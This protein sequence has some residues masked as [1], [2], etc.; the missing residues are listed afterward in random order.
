MRSLS[1]AP[2]DALVLVLGFLCGAGRHALRSTCTAMYALRT[3]SKTRLVVPAGSWKAWDLCQR[4]QQSPT[5]LPFWGCHTDRLVLLVR[6]VR[7]DQGVPEGLLTALRLVLGDRQPALVEVRACGDGEGQQVGKVLR[8]ANR[9]AEKGP[10]PSAEIGI[11]FPDD[12]YCWDDVKVR[13][14]GPRLRERLAYIDAGNLL[15]SGT[16]PLPTFPVLRRLCQHEEGQNGC[17]ALLADPDPGAKFPAV[18]S[19]S[20]IVGRSGALLAGVRP[21]APRLKSFA[22]YCDCT[23]DRA[24]HPIELGPETAVDL[25]GGDAYRY[26]HGGHLVTFDYPRRRGPPPRDAFLAAAE[27]VG[28]W[29]HAQPPQDLSGCLELKC[30]DDGPTGGEPILATAV[31]RAPKL[32]RIFAGPLFVDLMACRWF[33]PSL[34]LVGLVASPGVH[35]DDENVYATVKKAKALAI[36]GHLI[37]AL[38][39]RS[40]SGHRCK[41]IA[42]ARTKERGLRRYAN[43]IGALIAAKNGDAPEVWLPAAD[44]WRFTGENDPG[45]PRGVRTSTVVIS[46]TFLVWPLT[47][48]PS[49]AWAR[50]VTVLYLRPPLGAAIRAAA[51]RIVAFFCNASEMRTR[52]REGCRTVQAFCAAMGPRLR[53]LD[54]CEEC[55]SELFQSDHPWLDA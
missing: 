36:L 53:R 31:R 30:A 40:S 6:T 17:P 32:Q 12:T 54:G 33:P 51:S 5:K 24:G 20:V 34:R 22:L 47:G 37:A 50:D 52:D 28:L 27:S 46:A 35:F 41:I 44:G 8:L 45:P 21:L 25:L 49:P 15:Y 13:D 14:I 1:D 16:K 43:R 3:P 55:K 19:L 2:G 23:L 26:A 9:L 4:R 39:A 29:A 42:P 48:A 18:E 11:A 7:F 38:P 10:W